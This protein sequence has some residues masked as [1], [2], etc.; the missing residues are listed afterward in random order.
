CPKPHKFIKF[1]PFPPYLTQNAHPYSYP[2]LNVT[3]DPKR[4]VAARRH[5]YHE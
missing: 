5:Q 4:R 3:L 2:Y 1:M